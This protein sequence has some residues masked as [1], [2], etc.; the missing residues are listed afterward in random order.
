[1]REIDSTQGERLLFKLT[2]TRKAYIIEYVCSLFLVILPFVGKISA[3]TVFQ[4]LVGLGILILVYAE[5]ARVYTRYYITTKKIIIARGLLRQDKKSVYFHP[6]AFVPDINVEQ[7]L[8]QRLFNV[9]TIAVQSS[10][11]NSFEIR[12]IDNPHQ[13]AQEIERLIDVARSS[14]V[15]KN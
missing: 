6:L 12:D 5:I 1:M 15:Q 10:D 2:T 11:V 3:V 4:V 9:G 8:L 14:G 13:I 7:N